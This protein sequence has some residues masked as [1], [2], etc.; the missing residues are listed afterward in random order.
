MDTNVE[1][2]IETVTT[3]SDKSMLRERS[4][5]PSEEVSSPAGRKVERQKFKRERPTPYSRN[6]NIT[7]ENYDKK[8]NSARRNNRVLVTNIPYEVKWQDL[9]DLFR[10]K[11]GEVTY[12]EMFLDDQ[13][14]SRSC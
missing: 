5:T 7:N 11:V 4:M 1:H 3:T 6:T 12:V 10:S 8:G 13:G 14:R 9:K 2:K